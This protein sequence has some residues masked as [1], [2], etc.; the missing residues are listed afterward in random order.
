MTRHLSPAAAKTLTQ[1]LT[2]LVLAAG[3]EGP[4]GR[5]TAAAAAGFVAATSGLDEAVVKDGYV[6]VEDL[7]QLR[8]KHAATTI[9]SASGGR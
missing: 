8:A 7:L 1:G 5:V 6:S 4:A 9:T 3:T 2:Q